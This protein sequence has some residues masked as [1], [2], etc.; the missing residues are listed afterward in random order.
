MIWVMCDIHDIITMML[1]HMAGNFGGNLF[2]RIVEIIAFG[3]IYFGVGKPHA[4]M[5][6][7]AKWLIWERAELDCYFSK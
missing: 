4:I 2:W 1:N 3:E 7:I 5:I 6:F